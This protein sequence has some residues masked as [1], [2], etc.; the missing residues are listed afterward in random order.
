MYSLFEEQGLNVFILPVTKDHTQFRNLPRNNNSGQVQSY[1]HSVMSF[2]MAAVAE[3]E[4]E[5]EESKLLEF[6]PKN[7]R[8]SAAN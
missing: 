3:F 5:R 1:K 2:L 6:C 4:P 7:S 8:P